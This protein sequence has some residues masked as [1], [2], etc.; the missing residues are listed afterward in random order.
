MRF[1]HLLRAEIVKT[2]LKKRTYIGFVIV[3]L[4]VPIVVLAF[5]AEGSR[6]LRMSTRNLANDFIILGNLFNGWFVSYQVMMT[7]WID[8]PLLITFV[9]GD[10]LAGEATG[11]TYRLILT[12]SVPR[13]TILLVKF[14]VTFLYVSVFVV[15]LG[16]LSVGLSVALL[17]G[18]D[19]LVVRNGILVLPADDLLWR[20]MLAYLLAIWSM[21]SVASIAF[22]TSSFVEN[23]IGPII[24]TMGLVIVFTILTFLP[25]EALEPAREYMFTYHMSV[26]QKVFEDPVP[27]HEIIRSMINLSLYSMGAVGGAWIV[28]VRKDI[29]S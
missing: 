14:L 4:V 10:M 27:W 21:T 28:F 11:G 22:F 2:F 13:S 8:I 26:W 15:F 29:L 7:L 6:F 25:I 18:G 17:G 9:A 5:Q 16:I 19:L 24:A 23:A 12:R 1:L 3:M 20:F